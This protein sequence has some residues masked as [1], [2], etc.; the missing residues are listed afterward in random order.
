[1]PQPGGRSPMLSH[2]RSTTR[3]TP[4]WAVRSVSDSNPA[5]KHP[6]YPPTSDK[7]MRRWSTVAQ[8][9]YVNFFPDKRSVRSAGRYRS[10]G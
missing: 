9:S 8:E 10:S 7:L 5:L 1:M 2:S 4:E 3:T 6:R